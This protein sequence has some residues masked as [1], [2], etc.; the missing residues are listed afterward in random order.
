MN[1][2][3]TEPSKG[4][5]ILFLTV[6]LYLLYVVIISISRK[7]TILSDLIGQKAQ[8]TPY[9]ISFCK[10]CLHYPLYIIPKNLTIS[11]FMFNRKITNR[12]VLPCFQHSTW[13]TPLEPVFEKGVVFY[14]YAPE[15]CFNSINYMSQVLSNGR[16]IKQLTPTATIAL[17]TNCDIPYDVARYIDVI[18][19]IH[20]NDVLNT[21]SK[22]WTI[23]VLYN[24][25]LPFNYSFII[26]T[27]VFPCDKNAYDQI[28][29]G[30][31]KTGNDIQF[32]SRVNTYIFASGGGV[33][34][35]YGKPSFTYWKRCYQF[36]I[37]RHYVDDQIPMTRTWLH[38]PH[39][40]KFSWL[41]SNYFFASHG[42]TPKGKFVGSSHCYRSSIVITGQIRWIHGI[43]SECKLM[44]GEHLEHIK[45]N[46]VYFL[47][48]EC[49]TNRTGLSVIF[50]EEELA[51]AVSPQRPPKLNWKDVTNHPRKGVEWNWNEPIHYT[52][53]CV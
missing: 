41:S 14:V 21:R 19:P 46:R 40:I 48:G 8:N 10:N 20:N 50:S 36:Q 5:E 18:V 25:Y 9:R 53:C 1:K 38:Y 43:P 7:I 31:K 49:E 13:P 22:E 32:S 26:D 17:V 16:Y 4:K 28:L 11:P 42:I 12:I 29:D 6:I 23:R 27:H 2:M 39:D 47:N 44:N 3:D 33:L 30:F 52:W 51:Q 45:R 24:A 37:S 34:S 15:M 35:K